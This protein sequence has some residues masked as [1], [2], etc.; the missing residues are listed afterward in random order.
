MDVTYDSH[1]KLYRAN[2]FAKELESELYHARASWSVFEA[3]N[4]VDEGDRAKLHELVNETHANHTF[5]HIIR[6]AATMT[7]LS[8]ARLS[9]VPKRQ[10][11][12]IGGLKDAV[13]QSTDL[14][15][16]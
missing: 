3:G 7:V 9:D 12:T 5:Q 11:Y 1:L 4:G 14:L 13:E 15:I 8:I 2:L 16:D 10:R 6:S